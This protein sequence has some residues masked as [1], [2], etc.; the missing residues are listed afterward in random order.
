MERVWQA[1]AGT[2]GRSCPRLADSRRVCAH[3]TRRA[4][5]HICDHVTAV[6]IAKVDP[7]QG[8]S[9]A[10]HYFQIFPYISD[11]NRPGGGYPQN[12]AASKNETHHRDRFVRFVI[13]S[14]LPKTS[15]ISSA[16]VRGFI[17]TT[18]TLTPTGERCDY[19]CGLIFLPE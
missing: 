10:M 6:D 14:T 17:T 19:H 2:A 11:S 1:V 13:C 15:R 16:L 3:F 5:T 8:E 4:L 18:F 9:G 7:S 12:S